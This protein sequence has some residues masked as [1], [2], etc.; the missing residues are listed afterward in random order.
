MVYST[1]CK[2]ALRDLSE[3]LRLR[4]QLLDE[5]GRAHILGN[6]GVVRACMGMLDRA[7]GF[8]QEALL[9]YERFNHKPGLCQMLH[10]LGIVYGNE[11]QIRTRTGGAHQAESKRAYER[12]KSSFMKSLELAKQLDIPTK[13]MQAER[14]LELLESLGAQGIA[15]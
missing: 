10:D 9:I 8:L 5:I 12:A 6:L 2:E 4:T 14:S 3:S 1:T 15:R 11:L 7:E 13:I